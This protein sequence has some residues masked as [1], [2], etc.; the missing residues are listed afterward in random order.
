[1]NIPMTFVEQAAG[2]TTARYTSDRDRH[3]AQGTRCVG[4]GLHPRVLVP[5]LILEKQDGLAW[6]AVG[7]RRIPVDGCPHAHLRGPS[8]VAFDAMGF[9]DQRWPLPR[10]IQRHSWHHVVSAGLSRR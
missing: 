6:P 3:V 7:R 1:M 4:A 2:S 5:T 10:F 8:V 9:A